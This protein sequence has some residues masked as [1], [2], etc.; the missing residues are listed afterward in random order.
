MFLN[1]AESRVHTLHD[2][3]YMPLV[4]GLSFL[5]TVA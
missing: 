4:L 3:A 1:V 2:Y 5:L